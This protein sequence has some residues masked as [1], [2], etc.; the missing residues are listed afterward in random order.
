MSACGRRRDAKD[1]EGAAFAV[2]AQ[3]IDSVFSHC[4][5]PFDGHAAL[6]VFPKGA[7]RRS[8]QPSE[9]AKL[10]PLVWATV[11]D[12]VL[13]PSGGPWGLLDRCLW[14][15]NSL[16]RLCGEPPEMP[17]HNIGADK[18]LEIELSEYPGRQ[19]GVSG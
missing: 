10:C 1:L 11:F 14:F 7:S 16:V 17:A 8:P 13:E 5:T 9:A 15:T 2:L 12:D 19:L 6:Q 3:L 4:E 18:P